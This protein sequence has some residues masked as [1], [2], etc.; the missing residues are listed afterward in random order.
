MGEI[1]TL[2]QV[3]IGD[4][5][6]YIKHGDY[7]L[8]VQVSRSVTDRELDKWSRMDAAVK[9]WVNVDLR[10][11]SDVGVA[12]KVLARFAEIAADERLLASLT[13][14][15]RARVAEREKDKAAKGAA[16]TA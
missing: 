7:G 10:D 13:E 3:W 8:F 1:L 6:W 12:A 4:A 16:A 5:T 11:R 14:K 15:A 2:E 9:R